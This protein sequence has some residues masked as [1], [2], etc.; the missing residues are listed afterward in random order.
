MPKLK[1]VKVN[2]D[3]SGNEINT[4]VKDVVIEYVFENDVFMEMNLNGGKVYAFGV[5][6]NPNDADF[7]YFRKNWKFVL[8]DLDDGDYVVNFT[9][10]TS[11]KD[12]IKGSEITDVENAYLGFTIDS[13]APVL[14]L[15]QKSIAQKNGY[16]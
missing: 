14:S 3:T 9:A 16:G 4:N 6:P 10:Y 8:D 15:S 11:S 12:H 13:S 7:S 2:F 5:D 1:E